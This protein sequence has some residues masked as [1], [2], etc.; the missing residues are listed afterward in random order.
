MHNPSSKAT[1]FPRAIDANAVRV[2]S[3]A[4]I[5]L[6]AMLSGRA[7]ADPQI[8]NGG[9]VGAPRLQTSLN[10][11]LS[12]TLHDPSPAASVPKE[13]ESASLPAGVGQSWWS[14]VQRDIAASEYRVSRLNQGGTTVGEGAYQ[15]PNRAQGFR[16]IFTE[17]GIRVVPR[18]DQTQ[19]WELGLELV[20][21]GPSGGV[22]PVAAGTLSAEGARARI[23]RAGLVEWYVN[24]PRGLEQGFTVA[25]P[26]AGLAGT[27]E[28]VLE[29]EVGGSLRATVVEGGRAVELLH[30]SVR[31]LR[32]AGLEVRDARGNKLPAHIEVGRDGQSIR[33]VAAVGGASW[34]VTVDPLLTS[35]TWTA[36]CDQA[37]ADFGWSVA[38]AGDV[39]G[40]GYDDVIV[41]APFYTNGETTEGRAFVYHGTSVGPSTSP[42][43]TAEPNQTYVDFG[44]SVA[45]AGDVNGDGYDDVIV[46]GPWY[47]NGNSNEGRAYVYHGSSGGL[48][49]TA[50]WT[51]ESNQDGGRLGYSVASAGDVN[52][53]GYSDVIVGSPWYDN[54]ETNEG[55]AYVYHG[56]AAGLVATAGWTAESNQAEAYFSRSVGSAGD[57]NNDGYADVIIGARSYDNDQTDEGRAYVYHGSAAGLAASANWTVEGN[58]AYAG[59]GDAVAS[60]GDVN[61]D[62]YSD[63]IVGA[64]GYDSPEDGEGLAFVYHGSASGLSVTANWTAQSDQ[65]GALFGHSVASAGDVNGDGYADVIVGAITYT[66]GEDDEGRAYVYHGS[67]SGL[68]SIAAWTGE[69]D[70]AYAE[71]GISVASAGDVNGDGYADIIVGADYYDGGQEDEGRAYVYYGSKGGT[72]AGVWI[73]EGG[74]AEAYAGWSV[75]GAGD[76]NGDGYAD[77]IVGAPTYDNGQGEEGRAF[78]YHGSA[79]GPSTSANWTAESDQ[80]DAFFG[81]T[82]ASAGDVNGDGYADVIVSA[83]GYGNGQTNEGRAY[84]FHGS[85]V[86]LS[87]SA[88]WIVEG[89]QQAAYLGESIGS[90]GDVNG[91]GYGDVIV[92]VPGYDNGEDSEGRAH[93]FHGSASGLSAAANWTVELNQ[94]AAMLGSSVASA[95]DVNGD[96]FSDVIIGVPYYDNGE[97]NEGR[98][99]VYHGSASGLSA[100]ASWTAESNQ[101]DAAFGTSVASAGDVNGDGYADVIVG[102]NWYDNGQAEEGGVFVYHGGG[103]GLSATAAWTKEPHQVNA[104]LGGSVASAGDVNGDGYADVIIGSDYYD[105]GQTDEGRAYV[106]HGS[107]TGL[108]ANPAWTVESDVAGARFGYSVA[109]AGDVNGDGYSDLIVGAPWYDAASFQQGRAY[110]YY[111]SASTLSSAPAWTAEGNQNNALLGH[112]VASVGDVNGDGYADVIVGAHNY[113][114]GESNEGRVFVY[115]GS[116]AGPA[117]SAS[118]TAEGN[119]ADANFG[120]S[121]AAAGDVNGDGFGDIVVGA[122]AYDNGQSNEGAAFVWLGS[123]SGLGAA[124]TPANADWTGEVNRAGA[125]FGNS[126]A[127]AGDVNGDGRG[128]LI[129]GAPFYANPDSLEGAAFVFLGAV[130][131]LPTS[132]SWSAEGNLA[133]AL[134]GYSVGPAGD[135]NGDGYADIIVGAPYYDNGETNEGGAF[136]WHGSAS[137]LGAAGTP[138]NADWHGFGDQTGAYYGTSVAT[139]GDVNGDGYSDIIV[140]AILYD[141]GETD[142]GQVFA[143]YGAASGL[144]ASASWTVDSDEAEARLGNSVATAG[145]VNGDGYADVIVGG[146]GYDGDGIEWGGRALVCRGSGLGLLASASSTVYCGPDEGDLGWSVASAGDVNGDGFADV[147]IGA[148]STS[149]GNSSEGRALIFYGNAGTGRPVVARQFQGDGSPAPAQPWGRSVGEDNFQVRSWHSSPVGRERVKTEVEGCPIGVPFGHASCIGTLSSSWTDSTATASGVL[150]TQSLSGLA[151]ETLYRWRERTL[152]APYNVNKAGI[153]APPNPAHGP[154]RRLLGQAFEADMRTGNTHLLRVVKTGAGGG[155]VTSNPVGI[156]CGLACAHAFASGTVVTLTAVAAAGANFAGWSGEGCSGLGACQVT[157]SVARRVEAMFVVTTAMTAVSVTPCRVLDTRVTSGDSAAWPALAPQSRRVFSLLG[158]CGLPSGAKAF[159]G[160]LTV[161]N[162]AAE[163]DLQVIGGHLTSTS[164]SSMWIPLTRARA[165]NAH[166]QLSIDG[167]QT[168]SVINT[169]TGTVHFI[170]DISG[171]YM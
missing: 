100:S 77:V 2:A 46:G 1:G 70:Q 91:D 111:G 164:T 112:S 123:A 142:E 61:R 13:G 48:V 20:G 17:R 150:L 95:G 18:T 107:A 132:A 145:D 64:D 15:A 25:T 114:N 84:V 62:G 116:A 59:F 127:A 60:A 101:A 78:A 63:V 36:E 108:L 19:A 125:Q 126:V 118:W 90:A 40:D 3:L 102:A 38:S 148:R 98:A 16:T 76:V 158:K 99:Y 109:S 97:T 106:F 71:Y 65:A 156:A 152:W 96:G 120:W 160:N 105:G 86:G 171:Y 115:H 58:Q 157:M 28:L 124:G 8:I 80:G 74:Q 137:G 122:V 166:V 67:A 130:S 85:A 93:V 154:W 45:S 47:D 128:D 55:R 165:N 133:D 82:V 44:Y 121:V 21:I 73:A 30:G 155:T 22:R 34:P 56:S 81:D 53:D 170:L 75:A 31:M 146:N 143:Y 23:E 11:G 144:P 139:A 66:N 162:G 7:A 26:P 168:I 69:S 103:S 32:Y 92:G 50:S 113:D 129:V 151:A 141:N 54:T 49:A 159:F 167:L 149:N 52:G 119:Q 140:G 42:S 89:D 57:V 94:V 5:A 4:I 87:A 12:A 169:T 79:I 68:S 117:A 110:L 134:F 104:H 14:A 9:V 147:I 35:T 163:G 83:I 153:I 43:W 72:E 51:A 6:V 161:V 138:A 24:G 10:R 135:V 131:G 29:L 33:L 88:S 37:Y 41:G 39:N 27:G 136:V